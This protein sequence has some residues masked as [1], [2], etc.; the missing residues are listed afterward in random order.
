MEEVKENQV[1]EFSIQHITML[2]H[3]F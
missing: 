3:W 2:Q 1:N